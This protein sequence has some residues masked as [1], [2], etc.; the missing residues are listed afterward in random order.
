[1]MFVWY[2]YYPINSLPVQHPEQG[3]VLLLWLSISSLSAHHFTNYVYWCWQNSVWSCHGMYWLRCLSVAALKN[4]QLWWSSLLTLTV[5]TVSAA[6]NH[7]IAQQTGTWP[8]NR[9]CRSRKG[10]YSTTIKT[11]RHSWHYWCSWLTCLVGKCTV[12][13]CITL[14]RSLYIYL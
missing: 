3:V 6:L 14:Q 8:S 4:L 7:Y 2:H 12:I 9:R 10:S 1:M 11:P 5:L 13:H